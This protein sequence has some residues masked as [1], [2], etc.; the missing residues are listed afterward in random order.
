MSRCWGSLLL[1]LMLLLEECWIE[2]CSC[3]CP[4]EVVRLLLLTLVVGL[5][6]LALIEELRVRWPSELH[7]LE[8]RLS[9]RDRRWRGEL[10]LVELGE[11]KWCVHLRLDLVPHLLHLRHL[12][13]LLHLL[14]H[15]RLL[16]ERLLGV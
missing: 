16:R 12:L 6:L 2:E 11:S 1:L 13:H 3:R 9:L 5:L 15:G 8:R 14:G 4:R 10:L 7:V